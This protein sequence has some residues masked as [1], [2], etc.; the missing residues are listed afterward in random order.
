MS[1]LYG[2]CCANDDSLCII[3]LTVV[4]DGK[5]SIFF[6]FCKKIH[7]VKRNGYA[8]QIQVKA[9]LVEFKYEN[10]LVF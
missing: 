4:E 3:H 7:F 9:K 2:D 5:S 10:K 6:L 8:Q 1:T